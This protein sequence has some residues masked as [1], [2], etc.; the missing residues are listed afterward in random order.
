[1]TPA[2]NV[3]GGEGQALPKGT[4]TML[5]VWSKGVRLG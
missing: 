5:V 2:N 3:R 1:M 4:V